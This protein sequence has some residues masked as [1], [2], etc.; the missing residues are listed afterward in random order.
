MLSAMRRVGF[1]IG[2]ATLL[3]ASTVYA[4]GGADSGLGECKGL[5]H[6]KPEPVSDDVTYF[7]SG[8]SV[9]FTHLEGGGCEVYSL[10]RPAAKATGQ[11]GAAVAVRSAQC[12]AEHCPVVVA[13]RGKAAKP[14]AAVRT[15][16]DCDQGV[17]LRPIRLFAGRDD[18]E[19]VCRVSSGAGWGERHLLIDTSA[20]ALIPFYVAETGSYIARSPAEKKAGAKPSCPLGSLKVEKLGD[21]HTQPL[22]RVVDPSAATASDLSDGRGTLP[23][24][25]L[26]IDLAH[27]DVKPTGAPD[28]PTRV[29]AHAGC[30]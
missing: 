27:H 7:A 8:P 20:G 18:L 23:A 10:A 28:V 6:G 22:I 1:V 26:A 14:L 17:D 3:A 29:D 30:R 11:F 12:S 15:D 16:V 5:P 21:D 4:D 25:Q 24:K 13:V 9:A 2:W 19:L